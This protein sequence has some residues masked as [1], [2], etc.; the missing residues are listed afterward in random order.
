MDWSAGRKATL[1]SIQREPLPTGNQL[2]VAKFNSLMALKAPTVAQIEALEATM[3]SMP[4]VEL[5]TNHY[6]GKDVY[7]REL[8]FKKGTVATGRVQRVDH[9]SIL[10][11]GHMTLWTPDRGVHEVYGPSITEVKHGMKRAGYAHTDVHWATA[12]GVKD[13]GEYSKDM[14]LEFLTFRYYGEYLDFLNENI[15]EHNSTSPQL[16]RRQC[17]LL[18][19]GE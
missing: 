2:I 8:F 11:S 5:P 13:A 16:T 18:D 10:I 4:Q 7:V 15:I 19:Q 9:V 17:A 1:S 6:F 12:H 14:L 3:E